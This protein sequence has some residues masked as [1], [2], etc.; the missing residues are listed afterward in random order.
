MEERDGKWGERQDKKWG[1]KEK[2]M[3]GNEDKQIDDE[4]MRKKQIAR[5]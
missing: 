3:R 4:I 5:E 2:L 1:I